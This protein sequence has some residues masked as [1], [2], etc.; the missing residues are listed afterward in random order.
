M[1]DGNCC[2]EEEPGQWQRFRDPMS[3]CQYW[4]SPDTEEFFFIEEPFKLNEED[5]DDF[6]QLLTNIHNDLDRLRA[7]QT[8]SHIDDDGDCTDKQ[9]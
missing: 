2:D 1:D 6:L 5:I 8:T 4:W 3:F 7:G 9:N